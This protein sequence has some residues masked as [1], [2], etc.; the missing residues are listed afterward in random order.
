MK[1]YLKQEDPLDGAWFNAVAFFGLLVLTGFS[2]M[3]ALSLAP[4]FPWVIWCWMAAVVANATYV[5][6]G[7]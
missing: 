7:E 4:E 2:G 5:L 1:D 6:R 3:F